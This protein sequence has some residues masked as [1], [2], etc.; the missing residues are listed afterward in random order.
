[1]ASL[2]FV[3]EEVLEHIAYFVA[4][5][6]LIGP[7]SGLPPLLSTCKVI[8][9]RLSFDDNPLLYA[10]TFS[11]K[12]DCQAAIRRLGSQITEPG[13]LANE[14][15]KRCIY[16]KLIKRRFGARV[17]HLTRHGG[18]PDILHDLLWLTY[19]MMLEN[20]GKNEQHL[21]DYANL[22]RW[23]IDYWFDDEGA[24]LATHRISQD[25]WP[26]EDGKNSIAMWLLW[27]FLQ[28]D[29]F[30]QVSTGYRALTTTLKFIAIA[31]NRYAICKPSWAEFTLESR[32]LTSDITHFSETFSLASP[33][34][35]PAAILVYLSLAI[36]SNSV[37]HLPPLSSLSSNA[38]R[39]E[40]WDAD[41][42]R[43]INLAQSG[44]VSMPAYIPGSIEGVWEG[45]FTYTEFTT[46]MSLLSGEPPPV[47]R[48]CQVAQHSQ[49]WKLREYH[50][51]N[52]QDGLSVVQALTLGDALRAFFPEGARM[53]E[54]TGSLDVYE[55]RR[56]ETLHYKRS[57]YSDMC[58]PSIGDII[59]IG[60]GHSAWGQFNLYGRV[61]PLDGLVS[62]L[63]EYVDRDRGR[64]LYRGFL[65][66]NTNGHLSGR[67]RD[68][69]T[70][71]DVL[72]YEG[73]F[74]MNR[75]GL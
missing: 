46:Y 33:T 65:V 54:L 64:W 16:L 25:Q 74:I 23:L 10:R 49:T 57:V 68:T 72:G 73:C 37:R 12:F 47:L 70:A 36:R 75:R 15:R 11:Y 2:L 20:D 66:G 48:D 24:S 55:Q 21:R 13:T 45:L 63:K 31:A 69:H 53:R 6:C 52:S 56:Q 43:C 51:L 44:A 19:L 59:I 61:R 60:E 38:R 8:Y 71:P 26:L 39:S 58:D 50:L 18:S 14:L 34:L 7:P 41:W 4:T 22:E 40:D 67:W 27:F 9:Q 42:Q 28:P 1:M 3:P 32:A 17:E 35:A 29:F 62:L 5:E 30:L